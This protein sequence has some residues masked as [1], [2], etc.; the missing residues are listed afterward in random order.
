LARDGGVDINVVEDFSERLPFPDRSFDFV[1]A[2]AV[3][4]HTSD[5]RAACREFFRVLR[6]GGTFV[7]A[8]EHVIS[9]ASDLPRFL[10][11]HPLHRFYGGENAFLLSEYK[12]AISA[13]GLRL[14]AAFGSCDSPMNYSPRSAGDLRRELAQR[15][16]M[17]IPGAVSAVALGLS[18]P[19]VWPLASRL[20]SRLDRRPGRLYSFVA[21]RPR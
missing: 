3:L 13:A 21:D 19:G 1:F 17:G 5:L 16:T 18:L 4:H 15:L 14:R 8:R 7:A 11:S 12:G 20:V 6:P 2:R 9:T 10:E